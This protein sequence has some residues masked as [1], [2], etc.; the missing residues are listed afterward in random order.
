VGPSYFHGWSPDGKWLTYTGGRNGEWDIYRIRADG[1]GSEIRLTDHPALDDGSEF[2]PDGRYIWFNS[3]RSGKMQL[4]R[5]EPDGTNLQRMTYDEYNNWFPHPSP[6][7]KQVVYLAYS[8]EVAP[9]D[10]PWYQQVYLMLMP[11]EGG[12]ARVIANLYGGQGTINVPSWSPDGRR[13]AFVSNSVS[14]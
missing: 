3:S 13:L 1:A 8:P 2:T 10:H 9:D 12:E 7:G 14:R 11:A 5:M 6:D 4:W